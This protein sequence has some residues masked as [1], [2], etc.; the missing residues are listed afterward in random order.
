MQGGPRFA[1]ALRLCA[2]EVRI[3]FF[4]NARTRVSAVRATLIAV[5]C[6]GLR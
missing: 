1:P 5:A 2:G 3:A 6:D 4:L